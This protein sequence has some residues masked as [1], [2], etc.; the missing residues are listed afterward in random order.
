MDRKAKMATKYNLN[1]LKARIEDSVDNHK[2]NDGEDP[3]EE[4]EEEHEEELV[5]GRPLVGLGDPSDLQVDHNVG[6]HNDEQCWESKSPEE[7]PLW[8]VVNSFGKKIN[9]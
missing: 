6:G 8:I 2:R 7:K 1:H 5:G 9:N 3:G 4:G